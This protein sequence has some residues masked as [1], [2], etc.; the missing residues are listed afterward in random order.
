ML[1]APASS[2]RRR[3]RGITYGDD[4]SSLVE[5]STKLLP[6]TPKKKSL[7]SWDVPF[8]H[9]SIASVCQ[10]VNVLFPC[11][12]RQRRLLSSAQAQSRS[13]AIQTRSYVNADDV[14]ARSRQCL[15]CA[16]VVL[17]PSA[18]RKK[19]I[20]CDSRRLSVCL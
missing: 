17:I 7:L 18:K 8:D 20:S 14:R 6:L 2:V 10:W 13:T 19:V 9:E 11:E 16:R 5:A 1:V 3:G 15:G 4:F 12:A